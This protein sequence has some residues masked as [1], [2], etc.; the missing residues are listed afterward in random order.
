[1]IRYI[2]GRP[3]L[4]GQHLVYHGFLFGGDTPPAPDYSAVAN[5]SKE[6]AQIM[7]NLGEK[8]LAESKRQYDSNTAMAAPIVTAQ[9]DQMRKTTA[10]GDDYYKY[11]QQYSRPVEQSLMYESLGLT[12]EQADKYEHNIHVGGQDGT[13]DVGF[14]YLGDAGNGYAHFERSD[15]KRFTADRDS[16][17]Y[18][19]MSDEDINSIYGV[20]KP[21]EG[22]FLRVDNGAATGRGL[23]SGFTL[24]GTNKDGTINVT[25]EDGTVFNNVDRTLAEKVGLAPQE[26]NYFFP[27]QQPDTAPAQATTTSST[28]PSTSVPTYEAGAVQGSSIP[29]I[30]GQVGGTV[31]DPNAYYVA[32]TNPFGATTY[33]AANIT[34]YSQP[35]SPTT[36]GTTGATTGATAAPAAGLNPR[37]TYHALPTT[38]AYDVGTGYNADLQ[39]ASD[40]ALKRNQEVAADKAMA[41]ARQGT[42]AQQNQL[43]RQGA[44]YGLSSANLA[45]AGGA[46]A[47][48]EGL[49]L[50]SAA[51]AAREKEKATQYAKKLDVAGLYKGMP[52]ASQG[53]Y[54]LANASG[55]SAVQNQM[56]PGAQYQTGMAQGAQTIGAGRS[57]LQSGLGG[58]LNAQTSVYNSAPQG[59]DLGGL[60][61]LIGAGAKLWSLSSKEVKEDKSPIDADYV[62]ESI[63][64]MPVES[65]KYKD[66]VADSGH[67]IGP[68]AEDMHAAFGDKVAPGGVGLDMV[69]ANGI[70]MAAIQG[71]AK[72]MRKLEGRVAGLALKKADGDAR[73]VM[74]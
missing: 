26:L 46:M 19:G 25:R 70:N 41:T 6:S 16:A 65:W 7:A 27:L 55:N 39:A 12:P 61:S 67:H 56:A 69:S 62:V 73:N 59:T 32:E 40:A 28:T 15:G 44:R 48:T 72:K 51:N 36:S 33:R 74:L 22:Q 1:M 38:K 30:M 9:A 45:N 2:N 35:T 47:A 18:F 66:G 31:I 50:A 21:T 71:L 54:G 58:I 68:Y 8:Q 34:G 5:A 3:M 63:E 52:S 43:F 14:K 23:G 11:L 13:A 64:N 53:A 4:N 37:S 17:K 10:Q 42:T 49:G 29:S 60:G 57:M 24:N 20:N